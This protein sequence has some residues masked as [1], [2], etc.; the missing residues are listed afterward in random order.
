MADFYR[1]N[2]LSRFTWD[3]EGTLVGRSYTDEEI[4]YSLNDIQLIQVLDSI[5]DGDSKQEII[6]TIQDSLNIPAKKAKSIFAHFVENDILLRTTHR[7]F[8]NQN[9]WLE[10][11]WRRALYFH[12][13][14]NNVKFVDTEGDSRQVQREVLSDYQASE[15]SPELFIEVNPHNS[16][17]LPEPNPLPEVTLQEVL[18]KRRTERHYGGESMSLQE[19]SDLLYHSFNPVY[20]MRQFIA[21]HASDDPSLYTIPFDITLGVMRCEDIP[22]GFYHYSMKEHALEP[23]DGLNISTSREIED[24]IVESVIGQWYVEGAAVGLYFVARFDRYQWIYRHSRALRLLFMHL[25]TH[26]Q[27]LLLVATALGFGTFLTPAMRDS[28]ADS[29]LNTDGYRA[30]PMYFNAIGK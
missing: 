16:T 23:I 10:K 4:V 26:S 22:P 17:S 29:L 14:T 11:N 12:I 24:L 5:E 25:S 6:R 3:T 9:Q 18:Q 21:D 1:V 27:R 13:G 30:S 2:E 8:G 20:E 28:F 7:G 15:D 19:L